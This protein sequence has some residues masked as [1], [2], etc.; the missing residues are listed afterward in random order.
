VIYNLVANLDQ[1]KQEENTHNV[2]TTKD[3]RAGKL[4]GPHLSH[5]IQGVLFY[6]HV[7]GLFGRGKCKNSRP[8]PNTSS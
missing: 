1:V 2:H 7:A 6:K 3:G 8:A 4:A 5:E